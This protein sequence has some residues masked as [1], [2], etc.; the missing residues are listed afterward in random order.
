MVSLI[1]KSWGILLV[2]RSKPTF[3]SISLCEV[4]RKEGGVCRGLFSPSWN[5]FPVLSLHPSSSHPSHAMLGSSCDLI[6]RAESWH[7][8]CPGVGSF[9]GMEGGL[10]PLPWCSSQGAPWL[11]CQFSQ[12]AVRMASLDG[13]HEASLPSLSSPEMFPLCHGFR[14]GIWVDQQQWVKIKSKTSGLWEDDNSA[15]FVTNYNP[16]PLSR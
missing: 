13:S 16:Y 3:C 15:L 12:F 8:N 11:F 14:L 4:L 1:R 7:G 6:L 9:A 10:L 5:V 2:I